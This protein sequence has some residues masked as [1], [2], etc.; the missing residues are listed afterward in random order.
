MRGR[1]DAAVRDRRVDERH[2]QR[3]H[4]ELALA[5]GRVGE[6]RRTVDAALARELSLRRGEIARRRAADA[7][8]LRVVGELGGADAQADL[9]EVDVLRQPEAVRHAEVA[10]RVRG[11]ADEVG[12]PGLVRLVRI[13]DAELLVRVE[14]GLEGRRAGDH[15][16]RRPRRVESG[17]GTVDERLVLRLGHLVPR[18]LLLR[19]VDDLVRV[20]RR[21]AHRREDHARPRVEGDDRAAASAERIGRCLLHL[22][23]DAEHDGAGGQPL[24]Q[25]ARPPCRRRIGR[26]LAD[27]RIGVRRFD[28]REPELE[29][30]VPGHLRERSV[31]V[32]P[33]EPVGRR[34]AVR[35]H[36]VVAVDD[37]P[38]RAVAARG[39]ET[40]VERVLG[41]RFGREHRPVSHPDRGD[42]EGD[43]EREGE[44]ADVRRDRT[45]HHV[46]RIRAEASLTRMRSATSIQFVTSDEPP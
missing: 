25:V 23:V 8:P 13:V 40:R 2:L 31:L 19:R 28:A 39:D 24:A 5:V 18:R 22:L 10:V 14:S 7:E 21:H 6:E 33:L 44:R 38:A 46:P 16:E 12:A 26:V 27:Q 15:L 37:L 17:R 34:H 29:R 4:E 9:R 35:E 32:G 30:G 20:V 42:E 41:E 11:G 36:G 3:R 45:H 43:G 1:H